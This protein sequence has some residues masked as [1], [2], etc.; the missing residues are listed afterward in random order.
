MKVA[1]QSS[2][3]SKIIMQMELD[4]DLEQIHHSAD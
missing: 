3:A 2:E 4:V 1:D